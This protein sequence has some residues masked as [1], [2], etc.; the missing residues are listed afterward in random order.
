MR[1][2]ASRAIAAI[3]TE[4]SAISGTS[5][6]NSVRTRLGWVRETV[7]RGPARASCDT[8]TTWHLSRVPWAY[9]SPGTCSCGGSTASMR[10][11]V[12]EDHPRV[13]ALLDD[14]GDEVA[15]GAGELAEA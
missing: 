4:P 14:A 2:P 13:V 11:E 10:A 7:T 3:S 12:D 5:S 8:G 6:A 9:F 15:L 1:W